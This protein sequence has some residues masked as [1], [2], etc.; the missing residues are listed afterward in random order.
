MALHELYTGRLGW[1]RSGNGQGNKILV[2]QGKVMEFYSE[3]V[4][5]DILKK[6]RAN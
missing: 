6:V 1:H 2:A 4:K 5:I 3:S